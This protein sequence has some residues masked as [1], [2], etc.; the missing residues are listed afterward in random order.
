MAI[1]DP[2]TFDCPECDT[3]APST[4]VPYDRLGYVVCPVCGYASGPTG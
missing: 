1:Q 4:A 3:K 2:S